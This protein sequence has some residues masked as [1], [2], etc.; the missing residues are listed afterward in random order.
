ML[1]VSNINLQPI[2][3]KY[4]QKD[5]VRRN[6]QMPYDTVSFAAIPSA[7]MAKLLRQQREQQQSKLIFELVGK[8]IAFSPQT[9][10]NRLTSSTVVLSSEKPYSGFMAKKYYIKDLEESVK[11]KLR[12]ELW[13]LLNDTRVSFNDYIKRAY[14][15][16]LI[17]YDEL[18]KI[19]N[20]TLFRGE[21]IPDS[22]G[23]NHY[24]IIASPGKIENGPRLLWDNISPYMK[25]EM[26]RRFEAAGTNRFSVDTGDAKFDV[27]YLNGK[28]TELSHG[29]LRPFITIE[30]TNLTQI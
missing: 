12:Q 3:T 10:L 30:Q 20:F 1:V 28:P 16:S 11:N 9:D 4:R 15:Y 21:K 25:K 2:S 17:S 24:H 7:D 23:R 27:T 26:T 5:F 18:P 29:Q 6:C 14:N 22:K 13:H 19:P 8:F